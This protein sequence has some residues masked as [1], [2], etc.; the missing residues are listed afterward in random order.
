M[1]IALTILFCFFAYFCIG[2]DIKTIHGEIFNNIRPIS[3]NSCSLKFTHSTGIGHVF[4]FDLPLDLQKKY[5]PNATNYYVI[6]LG[7]GL[8]SIPA[9][10]NVTTNKMTR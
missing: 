7:Y 4:Q 3:T 10:N 1:K 5:F 9:T 6:V 2:E 8:D